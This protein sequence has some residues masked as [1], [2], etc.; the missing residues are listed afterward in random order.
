MILTVVLTKNPLLSDRHV[1]LFKKLIVPHNKNLLFYPS[2]ADPESIIKVLNPTKA[3]CIGP[4]FDQKHYAIFQHLNSWVL[5]I[6]DLTYILNHSSHIAKS[7]KSIS[8]F[9][10]DGYENDSSVKKGL[11][12]VTRHG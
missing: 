10:G 2:S 12:N 6:P 11:S 5:Q 9:L 8:E 7:C 4:Y 3:I 1:T